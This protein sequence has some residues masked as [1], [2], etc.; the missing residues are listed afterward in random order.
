MKEQYPLFF[1]QRFKGKVLFNVPMREYTS[2]GIGGPAD[3]MAFPSDEAD[4]KDLL[5]F[6]TSKHFPMYMLG[7]GTN[8]LVRDKGIRGVLVNMD[9]GFKDI[10]WKKETSKKASLV[11]GAGVKFVKCSRICAEKGLAGLEFACSIPGTVGGAVVM[12]AGAYG[13]EIKDVLEGVEILDKKGKK[14]YL[15]A[16]D[17]GLEYRNS[18]LPI[19]SFIVRV[20]MSL[21]KSTVE[22]VGARVQDLKER[23][24]K[25]SPI[26]FP[27]AGSIFK[28]PEGYIAGKL[29]DE[30]GL[31]GK[32]I[33]DAG[34]SE[35]HANYI[36]NHGRATAKDVI[37]LM[38]LI[39]DKIHST[40]GVVLEPEIKVVGEG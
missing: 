14:H 23:R 34:I 2:I 10:T 40:L 15:P 13:Q 21:A 29:I 36:V 27:N 8:I 22:D 31:K 28:N 17:L 6:A 19:G 7:S 25:T 18:T 32:R 4:L 9:D 26:K 5:K 35:V 1:I 11:V 37:A 12:N 33:G 39:R 38:S 3:V 16:A 30:A 24:K 20:H